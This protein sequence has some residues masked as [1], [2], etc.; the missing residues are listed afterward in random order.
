MDTRIQNIQSALSA[1]RTA[2]LQVPGAAAGDPGKCWWERSF[3]ALRGI[4]RV[5]V[6]TLAGSR[7]NLR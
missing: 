3:V 7:I 6:L 4:A 2:L 1:L 5:Q